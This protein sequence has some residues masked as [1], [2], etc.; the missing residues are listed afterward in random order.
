VT[1]AVDAP[2]AD[3]KERVGAKLITIDEAAKLIRSGDR[4]AFT[5]GREPHALALAIA[6][7]KD[8][9]RGVRIFSPSPTHDIPWFDDGWRDSFEITVGYVFPRG[10]AREAFD[11]R[12]LDQS[13]GTIFFGPADTREP[14]DVVL[15]E[16]T[17]P[18]EHGFCGFGPSVYNKPDQVR[19]ARL[20]IA[21]VN[22]RLIRTYGDNW[23][24]MS[25]IDYFVEHPRSG[26]VPGQTDLLNR[27]HTE[28]TPVQRAIAA[29]RLSISPFHT[30]RA[31]S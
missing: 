28:P 23:I 22:E 5:T 24:H 14:D 13:I 7:R 21:E 3:W 16:V 11:D 15:T 9:L 12:R 6:A 20:A 31:S 30:A 18:D 4:V 2:A 1:Q 26:R 8:E 17:P 29:G 19:K 10:S 27:P 25:E